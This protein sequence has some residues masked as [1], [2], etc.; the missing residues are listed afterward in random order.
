MSQQSLRQASVRALTG[1]ANPSEGDWHA[2][3]DT[4]GIAGGP[5]D[6]RLL[7]WLNA[8]LGAAYGDLAGAQQAFAAWGVP[9]ADFSFAAP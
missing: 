4:A 6:G 1:T 3:F 9:V 5:F 8:Q 2:L 7:A